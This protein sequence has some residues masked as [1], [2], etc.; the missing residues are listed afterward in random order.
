MCT[1]PRPY[2]RW[3]GG[4][5]PYSRVFRPACLCCHGSEF[6]RVGL[7]SLSAAILPRSVQTGLGSGSVPAAF[8]PTPALPLCNAFFCLYHYITIAFSLACAQYAL[9]SHTRPPLG[10]GAKGATA[11]DTLRYAAACCYAAI[12]KNRFYSHRLIAAVEEDYSLGGDMQ[13]VSHLKA[14]RFSWVGR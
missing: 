11:E 7:E 6:T 3:A 4:C 9:R 1:A 2:H 14:T 10:R 13:A 5:A 12:S 8:H